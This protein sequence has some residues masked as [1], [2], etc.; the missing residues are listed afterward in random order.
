MSLKRTLFII[1]VFL[2]YGSIGAGLSLLVTF[3][4][5]FTGIHG[6]YIAAAAFTVYVF[7]LVHFRDTWFDFMSC[8]WNLFCVEEEEEEDNDVETP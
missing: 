3:L 8:M 2:F 7:C 1:W 4:A 5:G 6:G